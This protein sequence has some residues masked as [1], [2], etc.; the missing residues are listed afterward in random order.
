VPQE[1]PAD[2]RWSLKLWSADAVVIYDWLMTLD[3]AQL[4][5]SHKAE[6]QALTDLLTALEGQVPVLGV[7]QEE[8]DRARHEVS[9]DMDWE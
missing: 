5:V 1:F 3:F 8:I 4:P 6:K 2:E 9:K 7:T